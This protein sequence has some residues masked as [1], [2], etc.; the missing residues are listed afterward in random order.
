MPYP[1]VSLDA[2]WQAESQKPTSTQRLFQPNQLKNLPS[3]AQRY[4]KHAIAPNTPLASAVRLKMQFPVMQATGPD[5][6][7]SVIGRMQGE[8]VWL[9]SAFCGGGANQAENGDI[10]WS[11]SDDTNHAIAHLTLLKETTH[12]TLTLNDTGHLQQ[13][14]LNRWNNPDSG[15]HRYENFGVKVEDEGTFSGYTIHSFRFLMPF[16]L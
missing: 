9:P 7:R 8:Y 5:V 16:A 6:T 1:K 12:L 15:P 10:A 3:S 13:A 14:S 2:L 4:L 11:A